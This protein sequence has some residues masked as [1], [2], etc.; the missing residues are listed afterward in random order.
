MTNVTINGITWKFSNNG[1]VVER[2]VPATGTGTGTATGTIA[3]DSGISSKVKI[4]VDGNDYTNQLSL[5]NANAWVMGGLS[6]SLFGSS[7]WL[8]I[9]ALNI[10]SISGIQ[11]LA[12]TSTRKVLF[13]LFIV[14][15]LITLICSAISTFAWHDDPEKQTT[16]ICL[17]IPIWLIAL[18]ILVACFV[19]SESNIKKYIH[20]LTTSLSMSVLLVG[21]VLFV[22][23][24]S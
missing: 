12:T 2:D 11:D 17:F 1:S 23:A 14:A 3:P 10:E 19:M 5:F 15:I 13:G 22:A 24:N 8:A 9:D 6:A 4:S 18:C 16:R 7:V 21:L 20:L